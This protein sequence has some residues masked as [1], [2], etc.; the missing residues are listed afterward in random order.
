MDCPA[1]CG[2]QVP[3]IIEKLDY[4]FEDCP[5]T[6]STCDCCKTNLILRSANIICQNKMIRLKTGEYPKD[7]RKEIDDTISR[8]KSLKMQLKKLSQGAEFENIKSP[9]LL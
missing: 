7:V 8:I 9:S 3:N 1:K 2:A 4:H 6:I 5:N